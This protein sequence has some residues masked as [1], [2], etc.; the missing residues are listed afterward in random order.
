MFRLNNNNNNYYSFVKNTIFSSFYSN[1]FNEL[2]KFVK[3]IK[4]VK[5]L[6]I[7]ISLKSKHRINYY[8]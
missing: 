5:S 2:L 1:Y 6:S 8:Y 4:F 3:I 7:R